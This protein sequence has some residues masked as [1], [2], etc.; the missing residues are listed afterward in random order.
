MILR[1]L[2]NI[3]DVAVAAH[4]ELLSNFDAALCALSAIEEL[5]LLLGEVVLDV[6]L[7]LQ[8]VLIELQ[9]LPNVHADSLS[10][11]EL[12]PQAV[13]FIELSAEPSQLAHDLQELTLSLC[14]L[15]L[16]AIFLSYLLVV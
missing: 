16:D 1:L 9:Y 11:D 7:L 14:I 2:R 8:D 5:V 10:H 3:D 6:L 15:E 12:A 4:D 13:A